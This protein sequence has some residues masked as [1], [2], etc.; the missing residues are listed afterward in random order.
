MSWFFEACAAILCSTA[1]ILS[2]QT[3]APPGIGQNGVVNAA[4]RIPPTLT[5]GDLARGARITISGVRLGSAGHTIVTLLCDSGARYASKLFNPMFLRSKNLP[6][7]D[8]LE[9]KARAPL[10]FV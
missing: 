8:W 9:A 5:G 7:P 10:V 1:A 2:A 6:V 3:A 4:S